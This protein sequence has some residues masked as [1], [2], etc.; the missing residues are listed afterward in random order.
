MAKKRTRKTT[1]PEA[2]LIDPS[3][4]PTKFIAEVLG[5]S[6]DRVSQLF[7]EGVISQN[8]KMRGKYS[9][10]VAV[11]QYIE[12]FRQGGTSSAKAKL[13]VQQERKLR[14]LNDREAGSLVSIDDAAEV[15]LRSCLAW[16]SGATALPRRLATRLANAKRA[17][18]IRTILTEEIDGLLREFEKPLQEYFDAA[19]HPFAISNRRSSGNGTAAP[20]DARPVGKRRK[21][22]TARKR[23][24][25]K[26]PKRKNAVHGSNNAR[27]S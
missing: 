22:T 17:G 21:N 23:R 14:L 4:V 2:D 16:R 19:G 12:N 11:P 5:L 7:A 1:E 13:A 26:V 18:D 27:N 25:G 20:T 9:L 15:F 3:N 8:G 24:A 10:T 6:P